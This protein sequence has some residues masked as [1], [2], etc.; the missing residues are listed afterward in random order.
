M[1]DTRYLTL[2]EVKQLLSKEE[3]QGDLSPEQKVALEHAQK[4]AK[5]D[6]ESVRKLRK[7]LGEM[8][9]GG[10]QNI[11][12]IIDILP[13]APEDVRLIFSKE[14]LTPEKKQIEQIIETV[15]KYM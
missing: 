14:R 6:L 4:F 9:I 1:A 12:K 11:V 13:S 10:E 7:E 15:R 3:R 8:D 2:A 5:L